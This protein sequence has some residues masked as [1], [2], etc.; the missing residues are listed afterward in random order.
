MNVPK[1]FWLDGVLTATYF[2]NRM[3]SKTLGGKKFVEISCPNTPLFKVLP[4]IF[5]CTC[6]VHIPKHQRDK[7]DANASSVFLLDILAPRKAKVL[8][9]WDKWSSL[10][11][12]G[13]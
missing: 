11:Y 10:C 6:F 4:K 2:I 12:N 13:C 3:P 7:L 5:R 9:S 1:S 8:C